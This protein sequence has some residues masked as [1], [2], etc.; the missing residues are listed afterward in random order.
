M[1]G[2]LAA[3]TRDKK[4]RA[5]TLRF[6]ILRAI[7]DAAVEADVDPAAA[8]ACLREVGAAS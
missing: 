6:V 7:G 8:E 2:L 1:A 4:V 3:M 5:G